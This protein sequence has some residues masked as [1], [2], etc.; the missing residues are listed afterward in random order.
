MLLPSMVTAIFFASASSCAGLEPNM[1]VAWRMLG[2]STR[3]KVAS[4]GSG[5]RFTAIR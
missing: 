5:D 3:R 4:I 2:A 1:G